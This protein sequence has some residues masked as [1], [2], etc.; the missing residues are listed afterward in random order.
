MRV[1]HI[2][3]DF[4]TDMILSIETYIYSAKINTCRIVLAG[5]RASEGL[6]QEHGPFHPYTP[7]SVQSWAIASL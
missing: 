4:I 6:T 1:I 3:A 5:G 7:R 2:L